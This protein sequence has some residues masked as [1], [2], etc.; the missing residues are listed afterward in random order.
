M[1][2]ELFGLERLR[3]FRSVIAVATY[4]APNGAE[5]RMNGKDYKQLA[6]TALTQ[7][8]NRVSSDKAAQQIAMERRRPGARSR[9]TIHYLLTANDR[10]R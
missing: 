9:F 7:S 1:F 10:I 6:P 5:L 2:I 3:S 4:F 8:L